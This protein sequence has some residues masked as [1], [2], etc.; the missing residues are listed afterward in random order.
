MAVTQ[1]AQK[2][3]RAFS[4]ERTDRERRSSHHKFCLWCSCKYSASA[5]CQ[6]RNSGNPALRSAELSRT[7]YGGRGVFAPKVSLVVGPSC[8]AM[9]VSRK[10]SRANSYQEHS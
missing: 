9:R 10:I 7:E 8:G 4:E 1:R 3:Q 2:L 5:S 6:G